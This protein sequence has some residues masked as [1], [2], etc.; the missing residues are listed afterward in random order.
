MTTQTDT[1]TLT[2]PPEGVTIEYRPSN[3]HVVYDAVLV[4]PTGEKWLQ[5][6][7]GKV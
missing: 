2:V 6:K 1:Q 3:E 7:N 5:V 4:A